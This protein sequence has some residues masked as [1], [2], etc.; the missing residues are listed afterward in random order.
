MK[1]FRV[2]TILIAALALAAVAAATAL[3]AQST[4]F[5]ASFKG[6]ATEK[7]SGQ[8]VNA[9]V[10]GTGTGNLV[11]KSTITGSVVANTSSSSQ[12]GCAPFSGPGTI[13]GPKGKLKVTVLLSSKGCAA[14]Q[15]DQDNISLS[16]TVK[17]NGGT[18]KFAKAKGNLHFSGHYNRASGAFTV[19][20]SGNLSL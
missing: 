14:G 9:S 15:D 17:A 18:G 4:A 19:K 3:A 10:K 2:P 11:G 16:G 6:T 1:H 5:T 8:T 20:L 12:T 13:S 7:V